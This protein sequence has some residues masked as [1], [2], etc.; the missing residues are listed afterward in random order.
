MLG[1]AC[2]AALIKHR[3]NLIR[4]ILK[5]QGPFENTP[6]R[7]S[8]LAWLG[9][10]NSSKSTFIFPLMPAVRAV[11]LA[12][13]ENLGIMGKFKDLNEPLFFRESSNRR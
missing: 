9:V 7:V 11:A 10:C 1:V 6:V 3:G 12:L 2:L 5:N 4:R 8:I 13:C